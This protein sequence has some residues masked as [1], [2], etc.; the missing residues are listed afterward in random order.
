MF[1]DRSLL[2]RAVGLVHFLRLAT[3]EGVERGHTPPAQRLLER[4]HEEGGAADHDVGVVAG[5]HCQRLGTLKDQRSRGEFLEG[6]DLLHSE[7][8]RRM[9][10]HHPRQQLFGGCGVLSQVQNVQGTSPLLKTPENGCS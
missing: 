7:L 9:G 1:E 8:S 4:P 2:H 3:S 6:E 10:L 5:V